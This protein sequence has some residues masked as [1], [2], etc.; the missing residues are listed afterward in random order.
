MVDK[1]KN[2]R[3]LTVIAFVVGVGIASAAFLHWRARSELQPLPAHKLT[4]KD[5][6]EGAIKYFDF[7]F[8]AMLKG[9]FDSAV[10]EH[11]I[12]LD[13]LDK[14]DFTQPGEKGF[15]TNPQYEIFNPKS[16]RFVVK[17][18]DYELNGSLKA[19]SNEDNPRLR[20]N[21]RRYPT[22]YDG[23]IGECIDVIMPDIK[24]EVC[25]M[26]GHVP[27][28]AV[29]KFGDMSLVLPSKTPIV[30]HGLKRQGCLELPDGKIY[31]VRCAFSR[32]R[33][34]G[35]S[36]WFQFKDLNQKLKE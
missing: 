30:V 28:P 8:F 31:D 10:R 36:D 7:E 16:T 2:N 23:V 12:S 25:E 5:M 24:R 19:I 29:P 6:Y 34:E 13:E 18:P 33:K 27:G 15:S 17:I 3:V 1:L 22:A 35:D 20:F 21:I 14:L 11:R 32:M 4:Q 26:E 9:S